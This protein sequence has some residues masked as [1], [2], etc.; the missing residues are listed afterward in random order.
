MVPAHIGFSNR[1]GIGIELKDPSE[2][3]GGRA[4]W[5]Y[6]SDFP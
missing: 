3:Y 2:L 4:R 6:T 5:T 1:C